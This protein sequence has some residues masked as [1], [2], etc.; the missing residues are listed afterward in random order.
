MLALT[1]L[2]IATLAAAS[3]SQAQVPTSA[4]AAK[5]LETR[6]DLVAEAQARIK[7]SGMSPDDV[8]AKLKSMGYAPTLFDAYLGGTAE[9]AAGAPTSDVLRAF[10]ALGLGELDRPRPLVEVVAPSTAPVTTVAVSMIDSSFGALPIFGMDMFRRSTSQFDATSTGV[11]DPNY[12]VGPRDVLLLV[13]TGDVEASYP[14]EIT[15]KGTVIIPQVGE[16]YVANLSLAE[17]RTVLQR[18][19]SSLYSGIGNGPNSRTRFTVTVGNVRT[20]QVFVV[21]DA[22]VPSSYQVS[23]LGTMLTAVYAAGGPTERGSMRQI[24]LKRQGQVVS[25]LDLYDYLLRGDATHDVRLESGDFIFIPFHGKRVSIRGQVGRAAV[26]EMKEG[27]TLADLIAFAGGFK[28]TAS[29]NRIQINRVLPPN[30]RRTIGL[31]RQVIDVAAQDVA[32]GQT[33]LVQLADEDQITVFAVNER[34]RNRIAVQGG[35]WQPGT[36]AFSAGMKLSEAL[37]RAGGIRPDAYIGEVLIS[38]R[39]PDDTRQELRSRF[40]NGSGAVDVD[41][42]LAED[43]EIRVFTRTEF[44]NPREVMIVGSVKNPTHLEFREGMTLRDVIQLSGGLT[45]GAFLGWAEVARLN[46]NAGENIRADTIRVP[47]DSSYL[48]NETNSSGLTGAAQAAARRPST[49]DLVLRPYDHI[50]IFQRPGWEVDQLVSIQGRVQYPSQYVI[51]SRTE[52]ISDLVT[53]AGGLTNDAY[54]DGASFVRSAD[55]AGRIN[56]DLAKILRDPGSRE[57]FALRAG[58]VLTIPR[59]NP[60]VKVLG[61]VH[62]P[63]SVAYVP[64]KDARYYISAAG[65]TTE[66]ADEERTY[67]TQPNGYVET[68]QDRWF[69]LPARIPQPDPGAVIIVP[70]KTPHEVNWVGIAGS[71]AQIIGSVA[72][73]IIISRR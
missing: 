68:Y 25:T 40:L 64:G 29:R 27:E 61:S 67:V 19:L 32:N 65:G 21:G 23:G 9:S 41:L 1:M 16:V 15:Q 39:Q 52:R 5:L 31:D 50:S 6:P 24:Q 58:D 46:E 49:Q 55:S 42:T 7:S 34:V 18:R 2:G 12:H 22:A 36:Q 3:E 54:A 57:N 44:A 43:D 13:I 56:I 53:R 62:A 73:V 30:Q 11:V 69:L 72:T 26:Y 20:N 38:R 35:V 71:V 4:Q 8:R 66:L 10:K 28:A 14:L 48:F 47:L 59:Y 45:E 33:P 70:A 51:R 63:T 60:V 37:R 17:V